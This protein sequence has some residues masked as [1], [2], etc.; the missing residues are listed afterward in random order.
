MLGRAESALIGRE[1]DLPGLGLV[2]DDERFCERLAELLPDKGVRSARAVY[3]RYKPRRS[4]LVSYHVLCRDGELDVHALARVSGAREKLDKARARAGRR[5]PPRMFVLEDR[6]VVVAIFPEDNE[7]RVLAGLAEPEARRKLLRTL[8][9]HD[10]GLD[11]PL[12]RLR[13]KPERRWVGRLALGEAPTAVVK[14]Y[15]SAGFESA[16]RGSRA[17][18]DQPP[19]RVARLL[20]ALPE[21]RLLA[22]EWIGGRA[23]GEALLDGQAGPREVAQAGEALACVHGQPASGLPAETPSAQARRVLSVAAALG[24]VQPALS[25]RAER[26][27][28]EVSDRLAAQAFAVAPTHGDFHAGQVLLADGAVALIDFDEAVLGAPAADLASFLAH[29][30]R[31]RGANPLRAGEADAL[32]Q[33]LL[34]GYARRAAPPSTGELDL[35]KA[36]ALF[37]I[38]PHF[39]RDRDPDWP[40][41]TE[42]VLDRIESLLRRRP[43]RAARPA[44]AERLA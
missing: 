25:G 26:L 23:L 42:A 28:Q 22:L 21:Q 16:L 15:A 10:P 1:R 14:A 41:R 34:D 18:T 29:L 37:R 13:Y 11:G 36:A 32:G 27:A 31:P 8:L 24:F 2:L 6:A 7:L 9:G 4:C 33:A 35:H 39:F 43:P 19:L 12:V 38:A 44:G 40:E 30:E 5:D 17:W 3:L 20:G